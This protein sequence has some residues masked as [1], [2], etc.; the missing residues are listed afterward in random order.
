MIFW[1]VGGAIAIVRYV[2]KDPGMDLRFVVLGALVPNLLDKPLGSV[3]FTE[4]LGTGRVFGHTLLLPA[5][6]LALV[7]FAT[8]RGAP[9]RKALLG[10]PIGWLLHVFLDGQWANPEGFWWPFLGLD[11]P[12]MADAGLWSLLRRETTDPLTLLAEAAGLVY[13]VVLARRSGLG[14]PEPRRRFLRTGALPL[15]LPR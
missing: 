6:V 14:K 4:E 5:V 3:L 1:Q 12:E 15:P 2:F 10:V 9:R 13:L 7:M 8:R 11:F